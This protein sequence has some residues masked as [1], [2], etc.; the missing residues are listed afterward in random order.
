[1]KT[2]N[3]GRGQNERDTFKKIMDNG[4]SA[5]CTLISSFNK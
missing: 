2:K 1:M 5:D 4:D 3:E